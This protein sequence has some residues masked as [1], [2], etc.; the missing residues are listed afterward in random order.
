MAEQQ[1]ETEMGGTVVKI[2]CAEGGR[3]A[4]GD[5]ILVV[6]AMKMEMPVAIPVAARVVKLLVAVGDTVTEGQPVATI[7]TA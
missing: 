3:L 7:E 6:E 5:V 4:E 2:E 1:V